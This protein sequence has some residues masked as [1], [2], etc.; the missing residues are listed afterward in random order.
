MK[1]TLDKEDKFTT[2]RVHNEKLDTL[3][4]PDLKSEMVKINAEGVKNIIFD[5]SEVRYIDSS[6]LSSILV[7]NRLCKATNGTFVLC[8]LQD[9]VKKL[10]SISQLD[11]VLNIT[12]NEEEA[13][14]FIYMEELEKDLEE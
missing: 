1:V 10:I 6:G 3:V 5:L 2:V 7:G 4:A 9:A 12:G 14:D 13:Q 11:S 8:N